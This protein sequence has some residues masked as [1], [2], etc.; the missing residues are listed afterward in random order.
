MYKRPEKKQTAAKKKK[1]EKRIVSHVVSHR[2]TRSRVAQCI[3][4]H[5]HTSI[6]APVPPQQIT[7]NAILKC[8]NILCIAMDT[9]ANYYNGMREHK[10]KQKFSHSRHTDE[11]VLRTTPDAISNGR[12]RRTKNMLLL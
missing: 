4:S 3:R 5:E 8:M 12:S 10:T 11:P 1:K 9:H 6:C 2:G 7:H